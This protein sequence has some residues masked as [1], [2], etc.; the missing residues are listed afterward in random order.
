MTPETKLHLEECIKHMSEVKAAYYAR[1]VH[2]NV[3]QFVEFAALHGEFIEL[4]KENVEAGVNFIA[5]GVLLTSPPKVHRFLYI[6]E[7]LN[8]IFGDALAMMPEHYREQFIKILL[9][10]EK[11]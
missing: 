6:A 10:G 2:C 1:A 4:C 3:H 7:K 9:T 8:C 5:N 11:E